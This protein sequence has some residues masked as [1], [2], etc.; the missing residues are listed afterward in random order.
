[1]TSSTD[2]E[3]RRELRAARDLE[4][5]AGLGERALRPDDALRDGRLRREE[6]PGD[7]LRRQSA[8]QPQGERH[9]GVGR[10]DGV[11][12]DEDQP[13]Q[14][15]A[16]L[17]VQGR[18]EVRRHGAARSLAARATRVLRSSRCWRRS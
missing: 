9:P 14:V 1:M 13:E 18:V 4:G 16:D 2:G 5:D 8:E 10:E 17:V 11:T 15:I 7:L 3:P 12:G 6:G